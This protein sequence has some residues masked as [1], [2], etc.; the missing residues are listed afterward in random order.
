MKKVIN[1]IIVLVGLSC[2][3][4]FFKDKQRLEDLE[5]QTREKFKSF[6]KKIKRKY[7]VIKGEE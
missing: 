3:F 2:C 5:I 6:K 1:I 7:I 4:I